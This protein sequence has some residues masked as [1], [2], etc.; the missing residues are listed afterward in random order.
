ML[1][2][3]IL[4]LFLLIP[5]S[6]D[7]D[8]SVPALPTSLER[9]LERGSIVMITQ[10]SANTYYTHRDQPMGFEYELAREFAHYLDVDLE[11][12]TPNWI[13]MFEM[14]EKGEGD[15]IA[16]G[17]TVVP[18][19]IRR[20][21]FTVPYLTVR[22]QLILHEENRRIRDLEDLDGVTLHVRA[23]TSYQER[24]AELQGRG[25][26][27]KLVLVPDVLT[28][29]LIRRVAEGELEAT[30]ADSNIALLNRRYY[31]HIRI[32][33][34]ISEEQ[35]LAWAVRKGDAAL[36]TAMNNFMSEIHVNGTLSKIRNLYYDDR[37][38]MGKTDLKTFHRRLETRLPIYGPMIRTAAEEHGFDWRFIA[39]MIYQE[40]HFD[41]QA[42]SYTGVR[43][44]MQLTRETAIEMGVEDRLDPE[45]SIKAGVKYLA[46]LYGLFKDIEDQTQRLLFALTSYNVGYGHVRDAQKIAREKGHDPATWVSLREVLPLLSRP[47]YYRETRHGYARG[48]EPVNYVN[49]I[50]IYYDIMVGKTKSATRTSGQST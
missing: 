25:V 39:A 16:A 17:V 20:V 28:E 32:A 29:E 21:D 31:P 10:N 26:R 48:E 18:S 43:G 13:Q 9:I 1:F 47:E 42:R 5:L 14:L 19:R 36:L 49:N 38:I 15:F 30:V 35:P 8:R 3:L 46:R 27:L 2:S 22:Q 23:G 40:S 11:V 34:P 37:N 24:L 7:C 50:L 45:Q 4:I 44:L 33:F 12:V 6:V 41:P